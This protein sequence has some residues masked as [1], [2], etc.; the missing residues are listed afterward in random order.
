VRRLLLI[1]HASTD[2]TRRSAFPLD[3][4][5]DAGALR[6]AAELRGRL[7]RGEVLPIEPGRVPA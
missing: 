6:D 2:A 7:G 4:P 5:L 1:R 3:E